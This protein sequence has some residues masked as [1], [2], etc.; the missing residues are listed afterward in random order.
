VIGGLDTGVANQPLGD[1]CTMSDEI[2][3]LAAAARNHGAF[4]SSVTALT[5]VWVRSGLITHRE[6]ARIISAA[7]RSGIGHRRDR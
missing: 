5:N 1:G 6:R 4:V 2:A 3:K 7:A